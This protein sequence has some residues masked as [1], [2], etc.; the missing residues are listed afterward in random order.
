MKHGFFFK[1]LIFSKM[2]ILSALGKSIIICQNYL[3]FYVSYSVLAFI[4]KSI[5]SKINVTIIETNTK[6]SLCK[7]DSKTIY[8]NYLFQLM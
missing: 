5:N 2:L 4:D 6:Y 8:L 1:C 3:D 7:F